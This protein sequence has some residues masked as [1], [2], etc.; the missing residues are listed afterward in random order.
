MHN[1][2]QLFL[3][4]TLAV[5]VVAMAGVIWIHVKRIH[6]RNTL[7]QE[8]RRAARRKRAADEGHAILHHLITHGNRPD[9]S[10][11]DAGPWSAPGDDTHP[12]RVRRTDQAT[13]PAMPA[14]VRNNRRPS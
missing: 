1:L 14:V 6:N 8:L 11:T 5:A 3:A 2:P 13:P 9:P 4:L 7:S 10:G 12:R